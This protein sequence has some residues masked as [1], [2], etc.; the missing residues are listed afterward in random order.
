MKQFRISCFADEIS[1]EFSRQ[2]E[3]MKR[4][5]ISFMEIRGVNGRGAD[6]YR[7]EEVKELKKQLDD[8][9]IRIS[10]LASPIG[11]ID[12]RQEFKPH[13][14]HFKHVVELAHILEAPY[15]RMFSFFMPAGE[16]RENCEKYYQEE[17]WKRLG[18]MTAYD[19]LGDVILLHENEKDIYGDTMERCREL[20]ERFYGKQFQ[21][22]FD[23][24]NFIQCGQNPRDAYEQLKDFIG[25]IHIKDAVMA[26]GQIV[27]AGEGDGQIGQ[28]L[29]QLFADG[30]DGFLS[31]EPHLTEF[32]GLRS[33]ER[34][35]SSLKGMKLREAEAGGRSFLSGEEAF[36]MALTALKK[37]LPMY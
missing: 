34:D 26:T 29:K 32:E 22:A 21:M 17:V 16:S 5:G 19:G 15:I 35:Q 8:A 1:P 14:E 23:F 33:L 24:A 31:L 25:Y 28:I 3:V 20:M 27:P 7:V 10:S 12:I 37:T 11:K 36:E 2:I 30:Y 13:L 9:G 18:L 6:T 4:L